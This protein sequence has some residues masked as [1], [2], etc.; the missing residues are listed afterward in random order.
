MSGRVLVV[1][2]C[3]PRQLCPLLICYSFILIKFC[4]AFVRPVKRKTRTNL[5]VRFCCK[6]IKMPFLTS[7]IERPLRVS[8]YYTP[9]VPE[10]L[11]SLTFFNI[12]DRSS[13]SKTFV[14]YVKTFVKYVKLYVYIKVYLTMNRMIGKEL[15]RSIYIKPRL[16]AYVCH[17]KFKF[18][19]LNLK[20]ILGGFFY[21]SLFF[22]LCF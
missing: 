17:P 11:M 1:L 9:F 6:G 21:H 4:P 15:L 19:I 20:L 3:F 16:F 10:Y 13:Y 7:L 14:K 8:I 22:S 2:L 18:S 12:F 5:L